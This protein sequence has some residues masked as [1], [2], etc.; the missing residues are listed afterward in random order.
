MKV[1]IIS[2]VHGNKEALEAIMNDIKRENI[3]NIICLG[4]VIGVGPNSKECMD[5]IINN[6]IEMVLG[7]HELYYIKGTSIDDELSNK[8][9]DYYKLLKLPKEQED[10]LNKCYLTIEKVY[11]GKKVSFE[12]FLINYDSKDDYPFYNTDVINA[13]LNT[14]I[15][16]LDSDLI[17]VGH[18]HNGFNIGKLICVAQSINSYSILDTDSLK[19]YTKYID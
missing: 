6:N 8:T 4:D 7:N 10:F 15:K 3:N 13:N 1:A 16:N 11:N 17:V 12:H 9:I 2:D 14:A 5:I 19:L 18:E